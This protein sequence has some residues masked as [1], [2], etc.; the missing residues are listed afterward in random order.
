VAGSLSLPGPVELTVPA[1]STAEQVTQQLEATL[2]IRPLTAA[3]D[4]PNLFVPGTSRTT[5]QVR[6]DTAGGVMLRLLAVRGLAAVPPGTPLRVTVGSRTVDG[7]SGM[8]EWTDRALSGGVG[9]TYRLGAIKRVPAGSAAAIEVP[10]RLTAPLTVVP[11]DRSLPPAPAVAELAW[12]DGGAAS[13]AGPP[14]WVV[15]LALQA[16]PGT[17]AVLVERQREGESTWS[18]APL[19]GGGGW[20]P[21]PAGADTLLLHDRT[22][23][24]AAPWSYRARR[25][26]DDGRTSAPSAE[27]TLAPPP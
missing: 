13:A 12:V 27:T 25:R 18:S 10:G 2:T 1:G 7:D 5:V 15:R 23:D 26:T 24:P 19:D 8:V 16:A 22:A 17:T 3:A 6:T 21:W 4:A 20:R 11:V 9:Y 14:S